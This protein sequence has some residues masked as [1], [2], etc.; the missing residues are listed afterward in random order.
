MLG[1]LE[2]RGTG[3]DDE[4]VASARVVYRWLGDRVRVDEGAVIA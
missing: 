3:E 4:Q 1:G 2:A